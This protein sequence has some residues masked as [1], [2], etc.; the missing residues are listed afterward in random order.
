MHQLSDS[1]QTFVCLLNTI[2]VC[3]TPSAGASLNAVVS[4]IQS[5]S[6]DIAAQHNVTAVLAG[7]GFQV[8]TQRFNS[9][10]GSKSCENNY[11]VVPSARGDGSEGLGLVTPVSTDCPTGSQHP[12]YSGF[13]PCWNQ[14]PGAAVSVLTVGTV[15]TQHL[16]GVP[17]LARDFVWLIPDASCGLVHSSQAWADLAL[18]KA[19]LDAAAAGKSVKAGRLQQV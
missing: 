17:W 1:A 19:A 6:A 18:G 16:Q 11:V 3:R 5:I 14:T 13:E 10:D 4:R 7:Q 12:W 15:L 8:H 9:E 2:S